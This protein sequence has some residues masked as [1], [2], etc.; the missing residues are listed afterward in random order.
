MASSSIRFTLFTLALSMISV[1]ANAQIAV[2]EEDSEARHAYQEGCT[3]SQR[4]AGFA[5]C[6]QPALPPGKRLAIRYV[7]ATCRE[8]NSTRNPTV[9]IV[10]RIDSVTS[11]SAGPV[12]I[13]KRVNSTRP[14]YLVGETVFLHTDSAP[15]A[16][17]TWEG[18]GNL[19]CVIKTF[20]YLVDKK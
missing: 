8:S 1:C 12:L 10:G 5:T 2:R 3:T 4:I 11:A 9:M 13:P 7:A 18:D 16:I 14:F 20:G 15:E 6:T 17:V 19:E